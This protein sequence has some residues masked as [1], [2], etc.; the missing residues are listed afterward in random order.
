M[1]TKVLITGFEPFHGEKIN[2]SAELIRDLSWANTAL[3]D[4]EV[5]SVLLPVDFDKT[6]PALLNKLSEFKPDVIV[7]L[8]QAGGRSAVSI[9]RIAINWQQE[10]GDTGAVG[11]NRQAATIGKKIV[12]SGPDAIF[13]RLPIEAMLSAG[14]AT[15]VPCE[16]SNSAGTFLCNYVFYR[17]LEH[18]RFSARKSGFIHLPFLPE[19]ASGRNPEPVSMKLTDMRLALAAI[20]QALVG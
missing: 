10:K 12:E 3:S 18:N 9:E 4:C 19:Q 5:E 16:I 13:S 11:S 8:G 15:G 7:E 2:P 14:R 20:L 6:W 17:V 1:K